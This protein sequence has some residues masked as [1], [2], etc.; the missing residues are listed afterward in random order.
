[1]FYDEEENLLR[2]KTS[3]SYGFVNNEVEIERDESMVR[4]E[5]D[6]EPGPEFF[7]GLHWR[8]YLRKVSEDT[9]L[10]GLESSPDGADYGLFGETITSQI[11]PKDVRV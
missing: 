6:M 9:V 4:F 3:F 10:D 11:N 5:I 2:R 8:R 1:M 7:K